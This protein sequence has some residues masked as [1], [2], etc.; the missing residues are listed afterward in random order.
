MIRTRQ[1]LLYSASATRRILNL[2]P[3]VPVRVQEFSK[4]IW[5]WVKGCRPTFI[6]KQV[7]HQHFVDRRREAARAL[8]TYRTVEGWVVLNPLKNTTYQVKTYKTHLSC[9]CEDY[10][11]QVYFLGRACCKHCYAVLAELG[12]TSLREYLSDQKFQRN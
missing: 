12:F 4:V 3:D 1:Q 10:R 8:L 6:S 11:N 7:Y 9:T 5:V 2:P